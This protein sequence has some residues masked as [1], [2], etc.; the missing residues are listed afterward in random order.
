VKDGIDALEAGVDCLVAQ[1]TEAGGHG[2]RRELG[3]GTLSLTAQL[4]KFA[5]NRSKKVPVLAAGGISDGRD[6]LSALSLGADGVVLG[7]R[8]WA[9]T[10]AKGPAAFKEALV[11]AESA[12]DVV[13]TR[14]FDAM[15]NSYRSTKWPPPY[16]SSG[17]LR[18][19]L[20]DVWDE[21]IAELEKKLGDYTGSSIVEEFKKADATN[22]VESACVF[23]GKGVGK[24]KAI[25]PAFDIIT[26]VEKEAIDALKNLQSSHIDG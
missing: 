7:T 20:T 25:E 12:D 14:V 19:K 11:A 15:W 9:S 5:E 23:S 3:T 8:L 22:T 1:G 17:A 24:I 16:D 18:N 21:K 4:V 10:E 6:F 13:R 26:R 2:V